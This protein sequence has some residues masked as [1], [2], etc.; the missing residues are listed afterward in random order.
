MR[1]RERERVVLVVKQVKSSQV[2]S[3]EGKECRN[4]FVGVLD[5]CDDQDVG[6]RCLSRC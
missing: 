4:D 6:C 2:K 3:T 1:Q 5:P